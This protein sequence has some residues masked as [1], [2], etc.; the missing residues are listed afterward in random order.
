LVVLE[1]HKPAPIN[2]KK[3][4]VASQ[5]RVVPKLLVSELETPENLSIEQYNYSQKEY[6]SNGD[7]LNWDLLKILSEVRNGNFG[8]VSF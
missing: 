3:N 8:G 1:I 2:P 6:N 7:S 4:K 5:K